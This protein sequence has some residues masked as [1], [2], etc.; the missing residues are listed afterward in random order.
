MTHQEL[1]DTMQDNIKVS[2]MINAEL[3]AAACNLRGEGK[4]KHEVHLTGVQKVDEILFDIEAIRER[5]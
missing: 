5:L 4:E 2:R 3:H 1:Q